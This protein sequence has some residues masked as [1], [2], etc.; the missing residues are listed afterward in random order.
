LSTLLKK[1]FEM[2]YEGDI[3]SVVGL[4]IICNWINKWLLIL[5]DNYLNGVLCQ[6]NMFNSHVISTPLEVGHRLSKE[7]AHTPQMSKNKWPLYLTTK[8]WAAWCTV[9]YILDWTPHTLSTP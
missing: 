8:Q 3:Y 4:G 6:Y 7:V 9:V 2:T 5:Q 1:D